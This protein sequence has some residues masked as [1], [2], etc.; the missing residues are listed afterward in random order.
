MQKQLP[1]K[2]FSLRKKLMM[3]FG[4]L[5]FIA[6]MI[7]TV[8][9]VTVARNVVTEKIQDHLTDKAADVAEIIDGRIRATLEFVEGVARM[10]VLRDSSLHTMREHRLC[11]TKQVI[12]PVSNISV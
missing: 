7:E 1:K 11:P 9:G 3:I 12:T 6:L 10:P 8:L 4:S 2:R 5:I